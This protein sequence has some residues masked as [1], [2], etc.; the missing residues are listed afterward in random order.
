MRSLFAVRAHKPSPAVARLHRELVGFADREQVVVVV[1]EM[2]GAD[3]RPWPEDYNL[4]SVN[5][6]LL[7]SLGLRTDIP[8]AGWR[9]GDYAY[10]AL[11]AQREFEFAWLIEPDVVFEGIDIQPFMTELDRSAAALIAADILPAP[12]WLWAHQLTVRGVESPWRC[13][14]PMTRL[15][16]AAIKAAERLR[17]EL[18]GVDGADFGHP[19]DEGVVATAV[20]AAGLATWDLRQAFPQHFAHFHHRPKLQSSAFTDGAT[21]PSVLHPCIDHGTFVKDLRRE[22]LR[23]ARDDVRSQAAGELTSAGRTLETLG[24]FALLTDRQA[25]LHRSVFGPPDLQAGS[26]GPAFR[27]QVIRSLPIHLRTLVA[28]IDPLVRLLQPRAR[29]IRVARR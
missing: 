26:Y 4:V 19:N 18:Q 5:D 29:G 8:D 27:R 11:A 7:E 23:A 12:D 2:H 25:A 9:C 20:V 1:D 28:A 15:S 24:D 16:S 21:G 6:Q 13:F 10:Y 14:F 3:R 22:L 17:V